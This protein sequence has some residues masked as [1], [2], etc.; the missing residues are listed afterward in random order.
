MVVGLYCAMLYAGLWSIGIGSATWWWG[1]IFGV[2][3][4]ALVILMLVVVLRRYPL[5]SEPLG[6]PR[7]MAA[8]MLDHI[9]FGIVVALVYST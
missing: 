9:I 8:I 6:S 1:L 3:H 5:L 7:V 2:V 4:G